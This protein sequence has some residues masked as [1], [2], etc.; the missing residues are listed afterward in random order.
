MKRS[1]L[2]KAAKELNEV[3]GL[4]PQ[5]NT[6]EK[7]EK[8]ITLLREAAT[9]IDPEL[10]DLTDRTLS[11]ITGLTLDDLPLDDLPDNTTLSVIAEPMKEEGEENK[12]TEKKEEV[13]KEE[14]KESVEVVKNVK[15]KEEKK[16]VKIETKGKN[17]KKKIQK[18]FVVKYARPLSVVVALLSGETN[19]EKLIQKALNYVKTTAS[20]NDEK[21]TRYFFSKVFACLVAE[22]FAEETETD[23][24]YKWK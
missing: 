9:L 5:I 12:K 4:D 17:K 21:E 24:I 8:L 18:L 1:E 3:L 14:V 7:P 13:A 2:V 10:D 20:V 16:K 15:D 19:K 11:V 23:L 6:K 22:G